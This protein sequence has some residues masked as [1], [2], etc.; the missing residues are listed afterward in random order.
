M[1]GQFQVA[2]YDHNVHNLFIC[3]FLSPPIYRG[4]QLMLFQCSRVVFCITLSAPFTFLSPPRT[5]WAKFWTKIENWNWNLFPSITAP[6]LLQNRPHPHTAPAQLHGWP[7][8]LAIN[9]LLTLYPPL[10]IVEGTQ[11]VFFSVYKFYHYRISS[12][13]PYHFFFLLMKW[14]ICLKFADSFAHVLWFYIAFF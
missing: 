6:N 13:S 12:V 11:C 2:S 3:V 14:T 9:Y 7:C 5:T 4:L 1:L 10:M 8:P